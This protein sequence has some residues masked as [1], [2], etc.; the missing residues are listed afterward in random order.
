MAFHSTDVGLGGNYLFIG[1]MSRGMQHLYI[2]P[3]LWYGVLMV[4]CLW[5]TVVDIIL[6]HCWYCEMKPCPML[7]SCLIVDDYWSSNYRLMMLILLAWYPVLFSSVTGYPARLFEL[8]SF[9]FFLPKGGHM[10]R[11]CCV[12]LLFVSSS[13]WGYQPFGTLSHTLVYVFIC[14]LARMV[15]VLTI[16]VIWNNW[17][18]SLGLLPVLGTCV[19]R[20]SPEF[21]TK[22]VRECSKVTKKASLNNLD[23]S[24]VAPRYV[25][26]LTL[27]DHNSTGYMGGLDHKW[28]FFCASNSC[29]LTRSQ[30]TYRPY[31]L[32][33]S[34]FFPVILVSAAYSTPTIRA[35]SRGIVYRLYAI[36]TRFCN[37]RRCFSSSTVL[38]IRTYKLLSISDIL[39]ET[40]V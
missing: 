32:G 20:L 19:F 1:S 30:K 9:F 40:L 4:L 25:T 29:L 34:C 13:S 6:I 27:W 33:K 8:L 31:S 22:W 36:M 16:L 11:V 21:Y 10:R 38:L 35:L 26:P 18:V 15:L 17:R 23:A 28:I 12:W 2:F 37:P 5:H 7:M 14:L 3:C 39:E 24:Q